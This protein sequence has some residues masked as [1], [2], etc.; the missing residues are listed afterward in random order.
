MM[1]RM[2]IVT[3]ST[4]IN[5][6]AFMQALA[7]QRRL[8][9]AHG[10]EVLQLDPNPIRHYLRAPWKPVG[11]V[12]RLRARSFARDRTCVGM[13]T[14]NLGPEGDIGAAL[15][16][17]RID[18]LFLGSDQ[19]LNSR[20]LYG[21][22][23][24]RSVLPA[25]AGIPRFGLAM[26]AYRPEDLAQV[27]PGCVE[28]LAG[29]DTLSFRE[30]WMARDFDTRF[31]LSGR[32]LPDPSFLFTQQ[33]LADL[34]GADRPASFG[35]TGTVLAGYGLR[36]WAGRMTEAQKSR[37]TTFINF[38]WRDA[39]SYGL[40][41][42]GPIALLS[43]LVGAETVVSNSFHFAALALILDKTVL[44]PVG[45]SI[46][47]GARMHQLARRLEF[48]PHGDYAMISAPSE[49][50]SAIIAKMR[51]ELREFIDSAVARVPVKA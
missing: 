15:G 45:E 12:G 6:G 16:G 26:S 50:R 24:A 10:I 32:V 19:V 13:R 28:A 47:G 49:R 42:G 11:M 44:V 5:F 9:E 41:L 20:L 22:D 14:V 43:Q 37:K 35:G 36:G 48:V 27:S 39:R 40:S 34:T 31:G 25:L 51:T 23:L 30:D 17:G 3:F 2:M 38:D 21:H 8:E 46:D 33:S 1:P 18:G 29:F 4:A 7:T